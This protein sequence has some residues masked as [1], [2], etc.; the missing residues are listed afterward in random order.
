MN[1]PHCAQSLQMSERLGVEI[2][3]CP[4]CRGVWLDRGELDKILARAEDV[5][6]RAPH[7]ADDDD[8]DED[9]PHRGGALRGSP[10]PGNFDK[11]RP[12]RKE[13]WLSQLFDW[14]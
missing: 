6:P 5:G 4:I 11:S 1:C 2:D 14:E 13:S 9:L 7:R 3:Y 10:P 8:S 12:P